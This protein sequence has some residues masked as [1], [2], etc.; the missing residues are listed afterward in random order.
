VLHGVQEA[1]E[2]YD[3]AVAIYADL[4]EKNPINGVSLKP[5]GPSVCGIADQFVRY[6]TM[7]FLGCLQFSFDLSVGAEATGMYCQSRG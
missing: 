5:Y 2:D 7:R 1:E 6:I 4:L 3:R